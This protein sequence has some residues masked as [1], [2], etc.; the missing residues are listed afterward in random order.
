M[1]L[2]DLP[3]VGVGEI[4]EALFVPDGDHR[5]DARGM[6]CGD[7][8]GEAS[9][10]PEENRHRN[11]R[12]QVDRTNLK[13]H[14]PQVSRRA[15]CCCKSHGDATERREEP[16]PNHQSKDLI[17]PRAK[18][19]TD[20]NSPETNAPLSWPALPLIETSSGMVEKAKMP[21]NTDRSARSRSNIG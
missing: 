6:A 1:R 5:M 15:C 9:D 16:L 21:E 7:V 4:A 17:W 19:R 2:V 3:P 8:T 18:R 10:G 14:C 20:T 11:Q 13:E 12:W